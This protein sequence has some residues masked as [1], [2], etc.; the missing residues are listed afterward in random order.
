[1]EFLVP[2][3][4]HC[5]SVLPCF[6]HQVCLLYI[7]LPCVFVSVFVGETQ[8]SNQP[9][10]PEGRIREPLLK[11]VADSHALHHWTTQLNTGSYFYVCVLFCLSCLTNSYHLFY[12]VQISRFPSLVCWAWRWVWERVLPVNIECVD[13]LPPWTHLEHYSPVALCHGVNIYSLE[14][15]ALNCDLLNLAS[16]SYLPISPDNFSVLWVLGICIID[17][18]GVVSPLLFF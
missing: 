15:K 8:C 5:P 4:C 12:S 13:S 7:S 18:L 17:F 14:I 11:V 9:P 1:M 16:E 2:Y 3:S 10:I 6:L